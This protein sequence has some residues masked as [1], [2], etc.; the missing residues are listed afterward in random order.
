MATATNTQT[1]KAPETKGIVLAPI[2]GTVIK[3]NKTIGDKVKAGDVVMVLEAMKMENEIVA[4]ID[5]IIK[6]MNVSAG[7][8]VAGG[9][10]LFEVE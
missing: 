10:L 5:G 3:V 2:P 7:K 4:S 8:T 1:Q 9:E 6:K